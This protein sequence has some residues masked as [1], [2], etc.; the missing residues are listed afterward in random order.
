M[1]G[2]L[3]QNNMIYYSHVNEDNRIEKELLETAGCKV[4]VAVAGSGERVIALMSAESCKEIHALDVNEEA[5]F[6]LELKLIALAHLE[7]ENYHQFTGHHITTKERRKLWFDE[8]KNKL[9]APCKKYWE[10]HLHIIQRGL[11]YAGH[12]ET[13]LN[14]VRPSANLFLGKQFQDI[15]CAPNNGSP[16]RSFRWDMLRKLYSFKIIYKLWGNK[17]AAFTSD[18]AFIKQI[19]DALDKVIKNNETPTCFMMHLIFKGHLREMS[20]N[21]LPPSLQATILKTIKKRLVQ[22]EISV[23][24]HHTDL[25]TFVKKAPGCSIFYSASDLLSFEGNPYMDEV[26]NN[27]R[28]FNNIVVWRTFLRNRLSTQSKTNIAVQYPAFRELTEKESSRMYQVFAV[29]HS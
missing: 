13:F 27:T 23:H 24:Y 12:F 2:R 20:E 14:K 26:V 1:H 28:G 21:D 22:N 7:I 8:L 16:F 15:F 18:D 6:L 9:R 11:L 4:A 17:D 10:H 5:L 3:I 29:Q 19:P 25:L